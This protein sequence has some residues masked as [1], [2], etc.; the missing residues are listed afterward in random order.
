MKSNRILSLI[1]SVIMLLTVAFP[2]GVFAEPVESLVAEPELEETTFDLGD[3]EE[4]LAPEAAEEAVPAEEEAEELVEELPTVDLDDVTIEGAEEAEAEAPIEEAAPFVEGYVR[5]NADTIVYAD[6]AALTPMGLF[7]GDAIAYAI[8]VAPAEFEADS[9]LQIA[10]DAEAAEAPLTGYVQ[11]GSVEVLDAEAIELLVSQEA[12]R[13]YLGMPLPVAPFEAVD[14]EIAENAQPEEME[15]E[16]DLETLTAEFEETEATEDEEIEVLDNESE[17]DI[18][19]LSATTISIVEQPTTVS[20][21]IGDQVTLSVEAVGLN[22]TYQWQYKAKAATTWSNASCKAATWNLK[23]AA[24]HFGFDFQCVIT[25][26]NGVKATTA[27]VNVLDKS[28]LAITKQP[29]TQSAAAG[30]TVA[31]AVEANGTGLTYQWQYKEKTA[32]AWSNASGKAATWNLKVAAVHFGF[33]F[34]CVVKDSSGKSLTTN[35]VNVVNSSVLSITTQPTNQIAAVG[36]TVKLSTVANGTGLTYQW[37]YK[38]KNATAWTNASGTTATWNLKVS[39][40]HFTFDFRCLVKDNKGNVLPTNAVRVKELIPLEILTQPT[41]K[42]ANV[43]EAVTLSVSAV[44]TGLTYQ[45]QYKNKT[46]TAWS[47]ASG[48]AASWKLT[49]AAVHFGFDFRCQIKDGKGNIL[50]TSTVNVDKK[51]PITITKQPTTQTA[52]VG[53]TVNLAVTATGTSLTYQW[54]YK[55]KTATAWSNAS[56]KAATWALKVAAVHFGFDFRCLIKDSAGNTLYTNTVNVN[57][58]VQI[59]KQPTTQTAAVGETVNLAVTATGTGLTYQWQYKEKTA[60]A[61]S[62][63][64]GKAATW[65]LKVAAVHFGFDFRCQIKDSAGNTVYTNTVNVNKKAP[66]TITKQPTTQSA[67]VGETVSL[68]VTATGT[69]LTYQWQF[70]EKTA[71][72]WINASGKTA[73]WNLKVAALH[74]NYDFRCQ[75]KDSAGN[76]IY[77]NVVNVNKKPIAITKQPTTQSAAVGEVVNLAVT[78]TGTSLTYQWQYKEKTATAWSNASSKAASWNL[79]VAAVHFGFDF[80]CQIKDSAGNIAYTNVVNV[81]KKPIV[82]TKQPT[83][84]TAAVGETVNLAVTATGTGLTYQWQYKNKTATD[85]SNAS[86]T[87]ATWALKVAA[88]HFGF[89][90]RCQIKDSAGN[91]AYTNVVNVDQKL[92]ITTQPVNKTAFVGDEVTLSVAATGKGL[93][94]QWQYKK[95]ADTTWTNASGKTASWKLTVAVVHFGFDFQCV[96]T[97]ESGAKLTTNKVN[98]TEKDLVLDGVTYRRLASTTCAVVGYSGSAASLVIPEKVRTLTV[99][100]IGEEAFMGKSSLTSIDLP[101]TITVIRA[102]AFKNCTNLS[103]M[104]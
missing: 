49:V 51:A 27:T 102:R 34:R 33:D 89:D 65:A 4:D 64:S 13:S 53:E 21:N 97:D 86:S 101:D 67:A 28:S 25:N 14:F 73:T 6:E 54:Q 82:I 66:I 63:A 36:E 87:S 71:T 61:W 1:L 48:R 32:T 98:I 35:T 88:V 68:A 59:T 96:I 50:Y 72:D 85:W 99:T 104:H 42:T 3:E 78:A 18:D 80:R 74:F 103:D 17:E 16:L 75:I 62:N 84:Q 79:T 41:S 69:S 100:E 2:A 45:W 9:W 92:A 43:G 81:N 90:F 7:I 58:K 23:V 19:K 29:E 83:T 12:A 31:L 38:A 8:V 77:T 26:S 56:G 52:A 93:T 46:A 22:L 94:Y 70:K 5:V 30:D 40:V 11:F 37:Q 24:V 76:I 95:T 47:N 10:F 20:A 60:T 91:I 57:Q 15:E 55:E 44:G 39:A